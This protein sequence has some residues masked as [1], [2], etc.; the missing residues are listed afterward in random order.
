[1][2][3]GIALHEAGPKSGDEIT[4][5]NQISSKPPLKVLDRPEEKTGTDIFLPLTN[6]LNG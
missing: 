2:T 6:R 1:V 4:G 5:S 3:E